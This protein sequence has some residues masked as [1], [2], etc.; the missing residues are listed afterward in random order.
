MFEDLRRA[1]SVQNLKSRY[2][3][4]LMLF[5]FSIVLTLF[6]KSPDIST[7][8]IPEI[9]K[10]LQFPAIRAYLDTVLAQRCPQPFFENIPQRLLSYSDWA[11]TEFSP[12]SITLG[13][14]IRCLLVGSALDVSV[15]VPTW[16]EE[17]Y[18]QKCL[19]SLTDQTGSK[20]L[21][22]I[23]VDG[24]STDRTV[25]IAEEFTDR[26]L[27]EPASAVARPLRTVSLGP[28]RPTEAPGQGR[29]PHRQLGRQ[30]PRGI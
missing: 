25:E 22:I 6:L 26:V 17:T 2:P 18:V 30:Q 14:R 8:S 12:E 15:I 23:V 7:L 21:E 24:G 10:L 9:G 28:F 29:L 1:G 4:M 3:A 19:R 16:N 13:S 27:V 11:S 5:A 20:P